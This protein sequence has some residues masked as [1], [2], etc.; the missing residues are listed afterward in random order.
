MKTIS[1]INRGLIATV[2]VLIAV[3][4]YIVAVTVSQD[5]AKPTIKQACADYIAMDIKYKLLPSDYTD[6]N[7]K[8][9]QSLQDS[10]ISNMKSD[11]KAAYIDNKPL[12]DTVIKEYQDNL[13]AQFKNGANLKSIKRQ[14]LKFNSIDFN[15]DTVVVNFNSIVD[16]ELITGY[17]TNNNTGVVTPTFQANN[18]HT[19]ESISFEKVDGKWK[20]VVANLNE[21]SS[22]SQ[23]MKYG[24]SV[25]IQ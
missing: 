13:E 16:V 21:P 9:P 19:S 3:I 4:T 2:I 10:I 1:K 5:T 20:V 6:A 11:I 17:T 24:G 18:S 7:K 15:G 8:V 25:K 23:G 12:V 22:D 14:I